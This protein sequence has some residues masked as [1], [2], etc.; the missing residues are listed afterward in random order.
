MKGKK[1]SKNC[2]AKYA[3]KFV[4]FSMPT[5]GITCYTWGVNRGLLDIDGD[6]S[7]VGCG[8]VSCYITA[9]FTANNVGDITTWFTT[10]NDADITA[11]F[12]AHSVHNGKVYRT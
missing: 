6:S 12:T 2:V 11:R 8:L 10:N 4:F 5:F 1:A 9:R 7:P 3:S